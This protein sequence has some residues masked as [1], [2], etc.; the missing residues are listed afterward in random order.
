LAANPVSA[1]QKALEKAI[2]VEQILFE[3][4][5][6]TKLTEEKAVLLA[7]LQHSKPF[8]EA[9]LKHWVP[10]IGAPPPLPLPL[11]A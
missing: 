10:V 11:N 8:V 2:K 5:K 7:V 4:T 6:L 9:V 3:C 1:L